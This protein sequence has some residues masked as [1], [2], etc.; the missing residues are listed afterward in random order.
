MFQL[1][2]NDFITPKEQCFYNIF[3]LLN[4]AVNPPKIEETKPIKCK[5]CG[6]KFE[7]N[8]LLLAHYRTH[9]RSEKK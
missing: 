6:A 7:N 1:N 8:G 5:Y 3:E 4:K 9:K 2:P